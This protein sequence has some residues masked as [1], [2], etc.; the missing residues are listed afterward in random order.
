MD[1]MECIALSPLSQANSLYLG[2]TF[3]NTGE[4][5]GQMSDY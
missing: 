3:M 4:I 2:E 5:L 1:L